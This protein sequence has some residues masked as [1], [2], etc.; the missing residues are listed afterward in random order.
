[1]VSSTPIDSLKNRAPR[2]W[3]CAR[4]AIRVVRRSTYRADTEVAVSMGKR[5]RSVREQFSCLPCAF[6]WEPNS[7]NC[8]RI[9]TTLSG[10]LRGEICFSFRLHLVRISNLLF[11]L[12]FSPLPER[13]DYLYGELRRNWRLWRRWKTGLSPRSCRE[14]QEP[15]TVQG[16]H[17]ETGTS[18]NGVKNRCSLLLEAPYFLRF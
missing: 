11:P 4:V 6:D 8:G 7:E 18:D 17:P 3:L 10:T 15:N 1:M 14:M 13:M 2:G 12:P 5:S 16:Y 9:F